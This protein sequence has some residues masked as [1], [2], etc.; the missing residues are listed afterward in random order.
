MTLCLIAHVYNLTRNLLAFTRHKVAIC[1]NHHQALFYVKVLSENHLYSHYVLTTS[2]VSVLR[3]FNT[4]A[5][6]FVCFV[7]LLAVFLFVYL[8]FC[9][10]IYLFACLIACLFVYL[11]VYLFAGLFVFVFVCLL[12]APTMILHKQKFP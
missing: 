6:L 1:V 2:F 8:F 3:S 7:Y 12:F 11:F 9:L 5:F 4:F 10:F